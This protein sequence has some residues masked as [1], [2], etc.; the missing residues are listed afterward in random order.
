MTGYRSLKLSLLVLISL[1]LSIP[2]AVKAVE[3]SPSQAK[4]LAPA[5]ALA[6]RAKTYWDYK[7]AG[8]IEKAYE[9]E[10]PRIRE[11]LSLRDYLLN[12]G[13]GV[14]WLE[15]K[16]GAVDLDKD[17]ARVTVTLRFAML[18]GNFNPKGG[19]K[20][21]IQ[22]KWVLINNEWYHYL[23]PAE[24]RPKSKASATTVRKEP[25]SASQATP[26]A[27]TTPSATESQAPA[28]DQAPA[29]QSAPA[30]ATP[31]TQQS[32]TS[33]AASSS[34]ATPKEQSTK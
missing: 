25:A 10:D 15:A 6:E 17:P 34:E 5:Q 8:Q 19:R 30:V 22:D 20:R 18:V 2:S 32:Q 14:K 33:A 13:G 24:P 21:T 9:L 7:V 16:I 3:P 4:P 31:T 23:K 27:T 28:K 11:K 12:V 26:P 29:P 1:V